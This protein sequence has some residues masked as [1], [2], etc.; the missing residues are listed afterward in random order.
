MPGQACGWS[1]EVTVLLWVEPD[2]GTVSGG[3]RYNQQVRKA[4]EAQGAGSAVLSIRADWSDPLS[5]DA[6]AVA[7]QVE[8]AAAEHDAGAVVVDGLIGSACP[9]LF[10][11]RWSVTGQRPARILL[12]HLSA[13]VALENEGIADPEAV[14]RE[15]L[16]IQ[17][18]D[19]VVTVS[20]WSA[21]E[22]RRR[23]RR[24]GIHVAVPGVGEL[25]GA[26]E[27]PQALTRKAP[28]VPRLSC[29]SAFLPV[30]N[31][32][33]LAEALEPL[34]DLDWQLTLA[35]PHSTSDYGRQVVEEL[36]RRLPGRVDARGVLS[37]D[38][39]QELWAET[40]LLLLP[41][42]AETYG[43]VV[44]EACAHGVPAFVS[45][46]TGAPEAAAGAG[47]ALDPHRPEEWTAA[48]R[49]WLSSQEVRAALY[50]AAGRRREV[51][52]RWE[53]AAEVF[54]RIGP[55]PDTGRGCGT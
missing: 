41:S 43:M 23:Y 19:H 21:A 34:L 2:L 4:L 14:R 16:A 9:E 47:H 17:E 18:A 36:E 3:L 32:R 28:G 53:E 29:V 27:A 44:T 1:S 38:Q 42:S 30:K 26:G 52:P 35:G 12:I 15:R 51:L 13:A 40:D 50:E 20:R 39:V 45:A 5:L 37:P 25:P 54:R 11:S 55:L 49:D 22:L 46:G 24:Q 31:H 6:S 7:A 8:A 10:D 48:L 33:L